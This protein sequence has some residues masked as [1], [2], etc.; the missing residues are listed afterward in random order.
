VATFSDEGNVKEVAAGD[1]GPTR[2][3]SRAAKWT[4]LRRLTP[5]EVERV[6]SGT[7]AV[8]D[9][10]YDGAS[11]APPGPSPGAE[12]GPSRLEGAAHGTGAHGPGWYPLSP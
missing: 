10:F 1:R 5:E 4:W 11:W 9:R 12:Q 8:A 3:D 7:A 2:R 6:R